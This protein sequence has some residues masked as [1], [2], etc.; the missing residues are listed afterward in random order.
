L[1]IF[2]LLFFF[3]IIS[4]SFFPKKKGSLVGSIK[5]NIQEMTLE[6]FLQK[7]DVPDWSHERL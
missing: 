4:H 2:F 3:K 1:N 5:S 6:E 7:K